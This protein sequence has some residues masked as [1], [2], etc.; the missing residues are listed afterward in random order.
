MCLPLLLKSGGMNEA[1]GGSLI[2][3]LSASPK[4]EIKK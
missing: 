3:E 4:K 2:F 1:E